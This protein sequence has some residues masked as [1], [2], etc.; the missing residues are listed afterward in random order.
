MADNSQLFPDDPNFS[1]QDSDYKTLA[2]NQRQQIVSEFPYLASN[3]DFNEELNDAFSKF[4]NQSTQR[5]SDYNDTWAKTVLPVVA[6]W[7]ARGAAIPKLQESRAIQQLTSGTDINAVAKENPLA[8]SMPSV[9]TWLRDKAMKAA[10][11]PRINE[12]KD[13]ARLRVI[14]SPTMDADAKAAAMAQI[15]SLKPS[16]QPQTNLMPSSAPSVA[17][18]P[19]V[20]PISY[21]SPVAAPQGTS[22]YV[23][24]NP[25]LNPT[26]II[27]EGPKLTPQAE[28]AMFPPSNRPAQAASPYKSADDVQAA[29]KSGKLTQDAAVKILQE[30][31]GM[32]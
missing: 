12:Q 25:A 17:P 26:P 21:N 32:Q 20:P 28:A 30:Q 2:Q 7:Q 18:A 5:G 23:N 16:L 29:Y 6:K 1:L 27:Y 15:D 4:V 19:I 10:T 22:G 24:P 14:T 11:P 8:L 13:A 31:F 3:T 9:Q